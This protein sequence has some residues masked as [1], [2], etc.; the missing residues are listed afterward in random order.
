MLS[1]SSVTSVSTQLFWPETDYISA[2][3]MTESMKRLLAGEYVL[4]H[5]RGKILLAIVRDEELA[6]S[7][8]CDAVGGKSQPTEV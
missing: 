8:L 4:V 6:S 3:Q 7:S 5:T 1:P 2:C